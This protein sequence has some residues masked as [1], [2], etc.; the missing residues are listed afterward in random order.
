MDRTAWIEGARANVWRNP[1]S[2]DFGLYFE[3]AISQHSVIRG[4]SYEYVQK[5]AELAADG[6]NPDVSIEGVTAFCDENSNEGE[7]P[8]RGLTKVVV[9]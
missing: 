9:E 2:T 4:G 8:K 7:L 1:D 3:N 5:L 6:F